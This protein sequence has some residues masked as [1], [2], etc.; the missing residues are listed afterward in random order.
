MTAMG[1]IGVALALLMAV[2][3]ATGQQT[4]TPA[5]GYQPKFAGDKAHSE[6]EAGAIAYMRTVVAAQRAYK[7]KHGHY[8]E[9]LRALVGSLSFTKRM[10]NPNRGEYKVGFRGQPEE[11]SLTMTPTQF[12][13][14]HRA[15][16]VDQRGEFR[17][18]EDRTASA[19][20]PPLK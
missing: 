3:T 9:S 8:A 6:A 18:E 12:D 1:R 15:F 10:A 20:S 5:T 4:A 7:R 17:A 19:K 11:Y 14:A 2:A 13:P 16:Y